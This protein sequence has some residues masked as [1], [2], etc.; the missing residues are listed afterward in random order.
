MQDDFGFTPEQL[1]GRLNRLLEEM[2]IPSWIV[3]SLGKCPE[4][5]GEVG[6]G[7]IRGLGWMLNAQHVGN[8]VVDI[9]CQHCYAGYEL[10]YQKACPDFGSFLA[11]LVT[12]KWASQPVPR[13]KIPATVNNLVD[14]MLKENPPPYSTVLLAVSSAAEVC[15][16]K[17]NT[18]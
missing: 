5:H 16:K 4:C 13:H 18:E 10:H 11:F 14:V 2:G 9:M 17:E 1:T 6:I 7:S 12:G 15:G 3:P 8:F